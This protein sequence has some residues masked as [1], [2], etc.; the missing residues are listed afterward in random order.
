MRCR[1]VL[2]NTVNSNDDEM[3]RRSPTLTTPPVLC[4]LAFK[5]QTCTANPQC[6]LVASC[7]YFAA[8]KRS[9]TKA[10]TGLPRCGIL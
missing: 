10:R 5:M 9:A 1:V 8:A 3:E 4:P 2:S 7:F 6:N